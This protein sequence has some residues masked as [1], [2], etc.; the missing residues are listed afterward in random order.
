MLSALAPAVA[1]APNATLDPRIHAHPLLQVGA[2]VDPHKRV[3]V[4]VSKTGPSVPSADLAHAVGAELVEEFPAINT[5]VLDIPQQAALALARTP[6]V[7]YVSPDAPV[8]LDA[9]DASHLKTTYEG[10]LSTPTAW[11]YDADDGSGVTVAVLDTGVNA[12]HPDLKGAGIVC[13]NVNQIASSCADGNGHG[14]HIAGIITGYDALGRYIGVAPNSRV[15]SVKVTDDTGAATEQNLVQGLQWVYNNR[16]AYNI[17]A[18]NLSLGGDTVESYTTNAVD[19]YIEQLW[20]AGVVVVTSAGNLGNTANATWYAP[21]NDPYAITVGALDNNLTT[22]T[23]DDS[24]ALFSSRGT[25]Q[26]GFYKPEIV[27]PGRKI[28]STLAG[29]SSVLAITYPSRIVD[30]NYII[31]SGTSMAAPMVTGAVALLLHYNSDLTPNKIKWLLQNAAQP[32]PNQPDTAGALNVAKLIQ[33]ANGT[34]GL[35]NQGLTPSQAIDPSNGTV[36]T[37]SYWNQ[38]YWNQSYWNQTFWNQQS[39]VY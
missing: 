33:A 35:A 28:A 25:T 18:V 20:L 12:S 15:I 31:M 38:S 11:N 4:L 19:A 3:R 30:S 9:I 10:T 22:S 16:S 23:A 13:V 14:T 26:D 5:I 6:G 32:Y 27:A 2:Q 17:K 1:A 8:H 37:T 29:P 39:S 21:G 7:R 34:L 24:L 36:S